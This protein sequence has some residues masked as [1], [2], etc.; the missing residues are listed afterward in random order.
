MAYVITGFYPF[1][2]DLYK[3]SNLNLICLLIGTTIGMTL[4]LNQYNKEEIQF[5][6]LQTYNIQIISWYHIL[7]LFIPLLGVSCILFVSLFWC[8]GSIINM[9]ELHIEI[10]LGY[11]L[12]GNLSFLFNLSKKHMIFN[13]ISNLLI[14][15]P[16]C[17][18][19]HLDMKIIT[20]LFFVYFFLRFSK[21]NWERYLYRKHNLRQ[22]K[23]RFFISKKPILKKE[24]VVMFRFQRIFPLLILLIGGQFCFYITHELKL[25]AFVVI[26]LI[27]I[28][29]MHDTWTLNII[30]LEESTIYLYIYSRLP[31]RRLVFTKW[32]ICFS[33]VSFLGICD[34]IF[35]SIFYSE[36][37]VKMMQNVL[38]LML[39]SFLTSVLY[40]LISIH[41][42]DFNRRTYY[43]IN[44]KGIMVSVVCV[45]LLFSSYLISV[46][47]LIIEALLISFLL[48]KKLSS[49]EKLRSFFNA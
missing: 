37:V 25:D 16:S 4:S 20:G 48:I 34:Y 7:K 10:I 31:L 46:N 3:S 44:V 40:I 2:E 49:E 21:Y 18:K 36:H 30:G 9:L 43:R 47:L 22:K 17:F 19:G 1:V 39:F 11:F 28:A 24:L 33:V 12:G 38:I 41:F 5:L 23:K 32:F 27:L 45:I 42:S 29:M 6:Y 8:H 15:I 14:I 13:F 35:W 26:T